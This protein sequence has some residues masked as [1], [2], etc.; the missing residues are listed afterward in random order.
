MRMATVSYHKDCGGFPALMRRPEPNHPLDYSKHALLAAADDGF[1]AEQLPDRLPAQFELV[2]A[3][4]FAGRV[5]A[6]VVRFP[7]T[8]VES[9]AAVPTGW[10]FVFVLGFD[11][12][13]VTVY[14]NHSTDQHATLRRDRYSAPETV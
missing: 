13:V 2:E 5:Y 6:W 11:Y 10:D 12:G 4:T 9:G 7:I 1:K 3:T 8:R 14:V